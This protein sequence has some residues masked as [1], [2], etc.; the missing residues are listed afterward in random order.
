M[1]GYCYSSTHSVYRYGMN[2]CAVFFLDI[3]K[4]IGFK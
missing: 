3:G 1:V 4:N 2:S